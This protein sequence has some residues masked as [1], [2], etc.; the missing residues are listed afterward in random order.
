MKVMGEEDAKE[1]EDEKGRELGLFESAQPRFEPP[2]SEVEVE[3][4]NH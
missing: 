1:K 3:C 2:T 4:A